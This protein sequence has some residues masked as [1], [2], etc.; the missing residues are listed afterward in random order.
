MK[1]KF[2]NMREKV[3]YKII[4]SWERGKKHVTPLRIDENYLGKYDPYGNQFDE[5]N[6]SLIELEDKGLI[7]V[8][9][10]EY[11]S[12]NKIKKEHMEVKKIE[13]VPGKMVSLVNEWI[14]ETNKTEG[15]T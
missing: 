7:R 9:R 1:K 8:T 10:K 2:I 12:Y 5:I 13:V 6:E 15:E 4:T 11:K 14:K 3:L